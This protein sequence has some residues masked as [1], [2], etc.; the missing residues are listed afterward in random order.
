MALRKYE[1]PEL[2]SEALHVKARPAGQHLKTAHATLQGV[3]SSLHVVRVAEAAESRTSHRGRP[4]EPQVD[5]LR[6]ALVLAG[7]GLEAVVKRLTQDTLPI[8][9]LPKSSARDSKKMMKEFIRARLDQKPTADLVHAITSDMPRHA[10]ARVYVNEL[11]SGSIQSEKDLRRL[12]EALGIGDSIIPEARITALRPFLT[13]RNQVAHDLDLKDPS[14]PSRGKRRSR[15]ITTVVHQ[16]TEAMAVA[17]SFVV[18]VSDKLGGP[19]NARNR[20]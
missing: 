13:A 11:T 3:F 18:A 19:P 9:L 2:A 12:R 5:L 15:S 16:C 14:D 7:A 10:M 4:T 20:R 1:L 6:S 8:L 17:E